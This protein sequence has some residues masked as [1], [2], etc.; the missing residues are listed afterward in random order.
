[1]NRADVLPVVGGNF[2]DPPYH[3]GPGEYGRNRKS[4]RVY[5]A[6]LPEFTFTSAVAAAT[7]AT[8]WL[9]NK[10]HEDT[11]PSKFVDDVVVRRFLRADVYTTCFVLCPA[12]A[13]IARNF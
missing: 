11:A 6:N 10:V 7:A 12:A 9:K 3:P 2:E 4:R 5:E 1:M 13:D 8:A